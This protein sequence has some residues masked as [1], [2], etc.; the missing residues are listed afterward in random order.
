MAFERNMLDGYQ[1]ISNSIIIG[2]SA[3]LGSGQ[4]IKVQTHTKYVVNIGYLYV[5]LTWSKILNL[6]NYLS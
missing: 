2:E 3:N 1:R 4:W 6:F 5:S